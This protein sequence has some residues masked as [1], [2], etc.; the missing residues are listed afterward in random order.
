MPFQLALSIND[1]LKVN[2]FNFHYSLQKTPIRQ[3]SGERKERKTSHHQRSLS[4]VGERGSPLVSG[5]ESGTRRGEMNDRKKNLAGHGTTSELISG[6][7]RGRPVLGV[8]VLRETLVN[9]D[10]M[11]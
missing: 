2:D 6:L 3:P 5:R 9:A 1:S 4:N 11:S 7:T 10:H 8:P